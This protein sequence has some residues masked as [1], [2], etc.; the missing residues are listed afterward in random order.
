MFSPST[1]LSDG[2]WVSLSEDGFVRIWRIM[3]EN[4]TCVGTFKGQNSGGASLHSLVSMHN[5]HV[6]LG[7]SDGEIEIWDLSRKVPS[8]F[9]NTMSMQKPLTGLAALDDGRLV[10]A[11]HDGNVQV[12]LPILWQERQAM[13]FQKDTRQ[14][15][16]AIAALSNSRL[17]T[18]YVRRV[19]IWDLSPAK[20]F[21]PVLEFPNNG[22]HVCAF[23]VLKE[24]GYVVG[25]CDNNNLQIWEIFETHV[26]LKVELSEYTANSRVLSILSTQD[27]NQLQLWC[28][29]SLA[30]RYSLFPISWNN[31][32]ELPSSFPRVEIKEK[33]EVLGEGAFGTVY[34]AKML[35]SN[36]LIAVKIS[37]TSEASDDVRKKEKEEILLHIELSHSN[38]L[39]LY[40][41]TFNPENALVT[42]LMWGSFFT[43][44]ILDQARELSSF[45][46]IEYSLGVA[47]GLLYLHSLGIIHRD[48]KSDNILINL[49]GRP[50]VSDF[51]LSK[52]RDYPTA[53]GIVGFAGTDNWMAP[54]LFKNYEINEKR[55][56]VMAGMLKR[57]GCEVEYSNESTDVYSLG[58]FFEEAV[59]RKALYSTEF[60][61][62]GVK[63]WNGAGKIHDEVRFERLV[64]KKLE[65]QHM[66][67]AENT[68][69]DYAALIHQTRNQPRVSLATII[70]ELRR[71][72]ETILEKQS[73]RACR[74]DVQEL[75]TQLAHILS[76]PS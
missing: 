36:E 49:N 34:K 3:G 38:I 75:Q 37:N 47:E 44:Y 12:C 8:F 24:S 57:F 48:I 17:L 41:V 45:E 2:R 67:L 56:G 29:G 19:Q 65:N 9:T 55:N 14:E 31:A 52:K 21:A 64:V 18:A 25:K 62:S 4:K 35:P 10:S 16:T 6:A 60:L 66:P 53:T 63:G 50:K 15:I 59:N 71:Q 11:Y 42:E 40:G 33:N 74:I 68:P 58:K 54:E 22:D 26:E 43:L 76:K 32:L 69:L 51:G 20:T 72:R 70:T 27:K 5:N 7:Y 39:P 46:R 13:V 28:I 1:T 73:N 61:M 23:L 30:P